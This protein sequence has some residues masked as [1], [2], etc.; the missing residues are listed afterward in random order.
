MQKFVKRFVL[1]TILGATVFSSSGCLLARGF[2]QTALVFSQ[3]WVTI[4]P[5]PVSVVFSQ[6]IEDTYE[7]EERYK[8]VPIL[9]PVEG[10]HA[11]LFCLDPPS[12]NEIM[13]ALPTQGK[14]GLA[15]L[16]ETHINNVR[17]TIEPIVDKVGDCRFIPMVGPARLHKCH[18]KCTVYYEKKIL[19]YWPVPFTHTDET[20][21]VVYI[22]HDHFIR[23]AGPATN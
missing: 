11:P 14:G 18:Y 17:Y 22:D 2:A 19:S 1:L 20:Q 13:H 6:E 16:A 23:C 5:I 10:E 3:F 15:L 9:D 21:E 4:A 7:I 8:K 12:L